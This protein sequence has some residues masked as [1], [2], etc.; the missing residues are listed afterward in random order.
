M[1]YQGAASCALPRMR[2]RALDFRASNNGL[3]LVLQAGRR[4]SGRASQL[5]LTLM[6][7]VPFPPSEHQGTGGT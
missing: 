4:R 7:E 3:E 2:A 6:L 1:Q 5:N